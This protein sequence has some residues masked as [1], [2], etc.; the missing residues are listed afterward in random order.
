M[1]NTG[2]Q[3]ALFFHLVHLE[4]TGVHDA[5]DGAEPQHVAHP[6]VSKVPVLS[7]PQVQHL[8]PIAGLLE[9]QPVAIHHVAGLAVRHVEAI[10]HVVAVVH[11][12]IHLASKVLLLI[13]PHSEGSPV[14]WMKEYW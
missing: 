11:Q 1:R 5:P 13:D 9:H 6:H 10:H 2:Y 4:L 12:L 3:L 14:L 8:A 7:W